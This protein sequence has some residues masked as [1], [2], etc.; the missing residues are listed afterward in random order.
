MYNSSIILTIKK[1]CVFR[2][3]TVQ[4]V[5]SSTKSKA[6]NTQWRFRV[7]SETRGTGK[8]DSIRIG[9]GTPVNWSSIRA[10]V[11]GNL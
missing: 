9:P 2:H 4:L 10:P 7:S 8:L 5:V 3:I 1:F 11:H 6:E